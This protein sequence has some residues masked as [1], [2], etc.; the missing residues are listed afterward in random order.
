MR[1]LRRAPVFLCKIPRATALSTDF[2]ASEIN[3]SKP[4]ISASV[5]ASAA[6]SSLALT[7]TFFIRVVISDFRALLYKRSFCD[8]RVR[9]TLFC[10]ARTMKAP[11][12]G[13]AVVEPA[14]ARPRV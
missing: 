12:A 11:R 13:D 4:L 9:A 2:V 7:K 8:N 1:A 14:R 3:V 5:H 6:M 10:A